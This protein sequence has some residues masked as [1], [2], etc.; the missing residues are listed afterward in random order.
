MVET[1]SQW[2]DGPHCLLLCLFS[3]SAVML[4]VEL[5]KVD[6]IYLRSTQATRGRT[7]VADLPTTE[8]GFDTGGENARARLFEAT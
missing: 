8:W 1:V 2:S 4:V 5:I 7:K 6:P 3:Q